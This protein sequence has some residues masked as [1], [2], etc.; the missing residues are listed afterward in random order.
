MKKEC[1]LIKMTK[2]ITFVFHDDGSYSV[3]TRKKDRR[4]NPN[5]KNFKYKKGF[6]GKLKL[7]RRE[8]DFLE[9]IIEKYRKNV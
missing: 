8:F 7:T 4:F 3:D 6:N 1:F 5:K 2:F 9:S